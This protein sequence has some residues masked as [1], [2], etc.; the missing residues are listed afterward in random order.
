MVKTTN[1][2]VNLR[3][4]VFFTKNNSIIQFIYELRP[5]ENED[6]ILERQQEL[7]LFN[8]QNQKSSFCLPMM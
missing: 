4:N 8:K 3:K 5:F 1:V 6:Y 7:L 2:E